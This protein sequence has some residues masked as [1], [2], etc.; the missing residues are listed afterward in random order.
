M[1]IDAPNIE[2]NETLEEYFN[3]N[4]EF[5]IDEVKSEFSNEASDKKLNKLAYEF[6]SMFYKNLTDSKKEASAA[7]NELIKVFDEKKIFC[8]F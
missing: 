7:S 8:L 6:C 4:K 5:W 3:R 2:D 1:E